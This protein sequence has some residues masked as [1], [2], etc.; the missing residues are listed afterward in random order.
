MHLKVGTRTIAVQSGAVIPVLLMLPNVGWMLSPQSD[1]GQQG[2][3]PLAL[4]IAENLGRAAVLG[5]PFFYS[6]DLRRKYST[7]AVGGMGL[8]LAVYYAA[9]SR[10]F[11][12]GGT[13]E[14]LRAPLLG[15]PSPLA[16][17]PVALLIL[18][19]YVMNSWLMFGAALYFG[20]AHVAV[21]AM[22]R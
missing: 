10:Y 4:T 21:L 7:V 18:S 13:A 17:A 8:A 11:V 5:L 20:A 22:T 19:S 6:L 14:L 3:A 1:G 15:I 12:G 2:S 9:W 16:V